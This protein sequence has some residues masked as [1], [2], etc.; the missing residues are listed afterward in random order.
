MGLRGDAVRVTDSELEALVL[1]YQLQ[2]HLVKLQ[3]ELAELASGKSLM[4]L[5]DEILALATEVSAQR[6]LVEDCDREVTRIAS[7]LELVEKRIA[8]DSERLQSSS[9]PKD[10]SGI[11]HEM[12]TLAKRKDELETNELELMETIDLEKSKLEQ[13]LARKR[14]LEENLEAAK[15]STRA[16]IDRRK[17]EILEETN[18]VQRLRLQ[19][20]AELLAIY[21]QRVSRGVPIGKLLKSTCG[22]CNMS[23]TST[24]MNTLQHIPAQELARCPECTAIL[25]R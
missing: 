22:A 11:Q 5:Q 2:T 3:A 1:L 25:V 6:S 12:E 20:S 4:A 23:L 17:A 19:P 9:N 14:V 24:A 10:I 16:E 15:Q 7:D 21:D 8:K 13:F 18:Q